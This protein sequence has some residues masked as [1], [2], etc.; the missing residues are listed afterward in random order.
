MVLLLSLRMS[1]R[2]LF[3]DASDSSDSSESDSDLPEFGEA[4]LLHLPTKRGR[5]ALHEVYP[6]LVPTTNAFLEQNDAGAHERRRDETMYMNGVTLQQMSNHLFQ[7]TNIRV[8]RSTIS[9]FFHSRRKCTIN[10]KRFKSLIN[11]RVP[12]KNNSG[13]KKA[14]PDF[15]CV[16]L[17]YDFCN[18]LNFTKLE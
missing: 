16:F 7:K 9:R 4:P 3:S 8:S 10:S 1:F 15:Q 2:Y 17:S 5:R 6:D 12:P 13:V 18:Q 11:A 14:N